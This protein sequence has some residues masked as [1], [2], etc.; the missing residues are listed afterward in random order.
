MIAIIHN[1]D[2]Y[3]LICFLVWD[4]S[5]FA[6][7]FC[8]V[9]C[10]SFVEHKEFRFLLP[11]IPLLVCLAAKGLYRL[12]HGNIERKAKK[13]VFVEESPIFFV[14]RKAL[15]FLAVITFLNCILAL[16]TGL[17][18]QRGTIDVLKY[19]RNNLTGDQ[20]KDSVLFLMPCHSTPYYRYL[21]FLSQ[22]DD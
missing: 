2:K 19:L 22:Y 9:W 6:L 8:K 16:Y 4:L 15:C 10:L 20:R 17:V 7:S 13:T 1:E 12:I 14:K 3:S 11:S 5:L 21:P 18:H